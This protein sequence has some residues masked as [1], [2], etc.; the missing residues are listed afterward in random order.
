MKAKWLIVVSMLLAVAACSHVTTPQAP[1]GM[2]QTVAM[3][4]EVRDWLSTNN[5]V[6]G[7][8]GNRT[9][10]RMRTKI[11]MAPDGEA[12]NSSE[13]RLSLAGD[14]ATASFIYKVEI[15]GMDYRLT[16]L[17]M[18]SPENHDFFEEYNSRN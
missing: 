17:R 13:E 12:I 2:Q 1:V 3:R 8:I 15:S 7:L 14:K 18:T 11:E 10:E 5:R 4:E 6:R 16:E 9:E